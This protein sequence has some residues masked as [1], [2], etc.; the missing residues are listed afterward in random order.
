[1]NCNEARQ[2]LMLY[3]DSEGDPELHF[4]ISEHLGACPDCAEWFA[5][6]QRFEQAIKERLAEGH[7][8]PEL[9]DRVLAVAG[10][11]QPVV[12][13]RHWLVFGGLL[14]MAA[15][16]VASIGFQMFRV[17]HVSELARIGAHWHDGWADGDL[18]PDLV[19]ASDE[20][21]DEYLKGQVP[22]RVHCPPRRDVNFA[23]AGAG[24]RTA[25]DQPAAYIVGR[26]DQAPVSILVLA[27]DCLDAFPND[28]AH[29]VQGAGRHRC[30]EGGYQMVS[31][32]TQDNVVVVIG[33][34]SP[35][36]LEKVLNAYGSY[37]DSQG[38]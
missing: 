5:K 17:S 38:T 23:V 11:A 22:F 18:T 12:P 36:T 10:I 7:T 34:A 4:R 33:A 29:L 37:H 13:R 27:R 16:T 8:A 20:Q 35:E 15:C 30:R 3:L 25:K 9:W 21:V 24:V 6:Q 19:S 28:R 26:V 1:M 32:I 2:H 31:G 14:A